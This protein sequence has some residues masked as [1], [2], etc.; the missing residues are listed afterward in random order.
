[1]CPGKATAVFI[2]PKMQGCIC[3]SLASVECIDWAVLYP[4]VWAWYLAFPSLPSSCRLAKWCVLLCWFRGGCRC[5]DSKTGGQKVWTPTAESKALLSS[6][7]YPAEASTVNKT[8]PLPMEI[9]IWVQTLL[10][11]YNLSHHPW[12]LGEPLQ[13][14][15][16]ESCKEKTQDPQCRANPHHRASA[17]SPHTYWATQETTLAAFSLSVTSCTTLGQ[18]HKMAWMKK[19]PIW[20]ED[21]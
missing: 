12:A 9:Y 3:L 8:K 13:P 2:T 16:P 11:H 18:F 19:S 17:W 14:R 20:G 1:M 4:F 6:S 10:C 5:F 7:S 15:P 21:C